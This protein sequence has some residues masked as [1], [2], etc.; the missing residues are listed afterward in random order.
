MDD[1]GQDT[2]PHGRILR[3]VYSN[4]NDRSPHARRLDPPGSGMWLQI[5]TAGNRRVRAG[6]DPGRGRAGRTIRN[7]LMYKHLA[8][9]DPSADRV[10][11][12]QG[13][14]PAVEV[15]QR[16]G[17]GWDVG[18][19]RLDGGKASAGGHGGHLVGA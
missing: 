17:A 11:F 1:K 2:F 8:R 12:G 6:D 5:D 19:R 10:G 16:D 4:V 18:G 9:L 15:D 7:S 14:E 13:D 3:T